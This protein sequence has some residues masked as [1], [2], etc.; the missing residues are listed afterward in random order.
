MLSISEILSGVERRAERAI[1]QELRLLTNELL[2]LRTHLSPEDCARVDGLLLKIDQLERS[3]QL[4]AFPTLPAVGEPVRSS[5][6]PGVPP[7]A[8]WM[9]VSHTVASE[10]RSQVLLSPHFAGAVQAALE[11]VRHGELHV[12][13]VVGPDASS[14]IELQSEDHSLLMTIAPVASTRFRVDAESLQACAEWL[15]GSPRRMQRLFTRHAE[16]Q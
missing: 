5:G 1:A 8:T 6:L 2:H 3:Q 16:L 15:Q 13:H 12:V 10:P 4:P 14:C 11:Q 9:V 7:P